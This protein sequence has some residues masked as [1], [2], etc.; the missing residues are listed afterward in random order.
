VEVAR[1]LGLD[2]SSH[3]AQPLTDEL[4]DQAGVVVG[5]TTT[6]VGE[7]E[8]R[9]AQGKARML[10]ARDIDDPIDRGRE[11]YRRTYLQIESDVRALLEER[12]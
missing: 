4:L 1:E 8:K 12:A 5:M 7:L 6:Q 9:G 2:L 3:R 10:G 11:T